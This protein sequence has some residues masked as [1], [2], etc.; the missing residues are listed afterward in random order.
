[1]SF[2]GNHWLGEYHSGQSN[3]TPVSPFQRRHSHAIAHLI[4]FLK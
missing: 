2:Y 4:L 3:I 1:M